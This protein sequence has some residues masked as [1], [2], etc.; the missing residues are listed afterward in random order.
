M[1]NENYDPR[2]DDNLG[3]IPDNAPNANVIDNLLAQFNDPES[4]FWERNVSAIQEV[5]KTALENARKNQPKSRC[6]WCGAEADEHRVVVLGPGTS[7][8]EWCVELAGELIHQAKDKSTDTVKVV[9]DYHKTKDP[10]KVLPHG[11]ESTRIPV[12]RT[13]NANEAVIAYV[14]KLDDDE[15]Y[16]IIWTGAYRSKRHTYGTVLF[17]DPETA[18]EH[19]RLYAERAY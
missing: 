16:V 11:K 5:V 18:I 8:C 9:R 7:V 4:A 3:Y 1:T 12:T 14:G 6:E 15:T 2:I 19:I 13:D 17:D 10:D